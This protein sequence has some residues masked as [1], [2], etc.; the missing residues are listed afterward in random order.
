MGI[1]AVIFD[2]ENKLLDLGKQAF[3]HLCPEVREK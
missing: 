3:E 2:T 1:F